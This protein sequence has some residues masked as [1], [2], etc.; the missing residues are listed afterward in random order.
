MYLEINIFLK[1][2]KIL[3]VHI[4]NNLRYKKYITLTIR[5]VFSLLKHPYAYK[6]I[7]SSALKIFYWISYAV[8]V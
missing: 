7:L 8:D 4:D 5:A 6:S 2:L 3:G 1:I